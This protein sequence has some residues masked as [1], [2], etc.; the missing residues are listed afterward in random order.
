MPKWS[1]GEDRPVKR[2]GIEDS[3]SDN[4]SI[5]IL[6]DEAYTLW[7][8]QYAT[9]LRESRAPR[10]GVWAQICGAPRE[11]EEETLHG[12]VLTKGEDVVQLHEAPI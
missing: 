3:S 11:F 6:G 1:T 10:Y 4:S 12:Y 8:F 9:T 7:L 5:E 2:L